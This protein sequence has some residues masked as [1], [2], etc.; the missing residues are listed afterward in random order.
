MET[1]VDT[2]IKS[3]RFWSNRQILIGSILGGP[4]AGCILLSQNYKLFNQNKEAKKAMWVGIA[5]AILLPIILM[6]LP[7]SLVNKIPSSTLPVVLSVG[8][9]YF[10]QHFHKSSL[11]E[12]T[13][14]GSKRKSYF[15]L[16]GI[17]LL[18]LAISLAWIFLVAAVFMFIGKDGV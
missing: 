12:L 11:K 17:S 3:S 4:L 15:K 16:F 18:F 1:T 14:K 9:Y 13:E 2:P 7:E 10:A 5:I 8:I 6:L